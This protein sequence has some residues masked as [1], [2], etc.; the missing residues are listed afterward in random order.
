MA[1]TR[2]SSRRG[3]SRPAR[4]KLV[5]VRNAQGVVINPGGTFSSF[6]LGQFEGSYGA[7]LIGCTVMRIRGV[8]SACIV[9]NATPAGSEAYAAVRFAIR[10]TDHSDLA[11]GDYAIGALYGNQAQA[12]WFCFEPF[13]LDNGGTTTAG[14]EVDT[15]AASE[16]RRIDVKSRRKLEEL[17]QVV[18]ILAGAPAPGS[19]QPPENTAG[20][21]LRWDLSYLVALP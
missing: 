1:R 15:T 18:E 12:D 14:N 16:I 11:I 7:Q 21:R 8:M 3:F 2:F 10:I 20:V 5:W 9:G 13:M 6:P 19:T 17:D 4:R